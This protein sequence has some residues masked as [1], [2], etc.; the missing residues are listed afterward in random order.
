MSRSPARNV[1]TGLPSM[2]MSPVSISSSP[3][4][5]RSVVVLPQ[6]DGPSRTTNSLCATVRF[7]FRM[8]IVVGEVFFDVAKYDF[9]HGELRYSL[10]GAG[11][12]LEKTE[13]PTSP[14][15]MMVTP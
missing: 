5:A 14:T 9:G 2:R 12:I 6:P 4:M 8:T 1:C 7:S 15:R 10:A 3:A 11:L 13:K